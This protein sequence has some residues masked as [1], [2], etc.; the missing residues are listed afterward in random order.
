MKVL[1]RHLV[2]DKFIVE[3]CLSSLEGPFKEAM[4]KGRKLV[5]IPH[6]LGNVKRLKKHEIM[7]PSP[8]A[9]EYDWPGLLH[10]TPQQVDTVEMMTLNDR[11]FVN[12]SMGTGKTISSLWAADYLMKK[13]VIKRCL[14]V[15]PLSTLRFT[16][17]KA[18]FDNFLNRSA[19]V[20]DGPRA[21]RIKKLRE[22]HDFYIINPEGL[23]I[24][25]DELSLRHDINHVIVD[26]LAMF[27]EAKERKLNLN[28]IL[29]RKIIR[30]AWGMTGEPTPNAPT[31]A[32]W[33][34]RL[35]RPDLYGAIGG[36]RRF[37]DDTM[38]QVPNSIWKWVPRDNASNHVF[39][40]MQPS[41]RYSLED[42]ATLPPILYQ[43]RS[44]DMSTEQA[45]HYAQLIEHSKTVVTGDLVTAVNA[46]VLLSKLVQVSCGAVYSTEGKATFIPAT[47]RLAV[48]KEIIDGAQKKVIVFAPYRA[49]LR[50]IEGFLIKTYGSDRVAY[51][52][53]SIS[54]GDRFEIMKKFQ[55]QKTLKVLVAH[56]KPI[57]HG[58]TLTAADTNV[59]YAP[60][61]S[62]DIYSQ[63]NGRIYRI[64]QDSKTNV[65]NLFASKAEEKIYKG[66]I[67]KKENQ[68][69]LLE[70]IREYTHD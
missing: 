32:Y 22:E 66:L 57:S 68:D 54:K 55:E 5:A 43:Y 59:W 23:H 13:G 39:R 64:S 65:I 62:N 21:R 28:A 45:D 9:T 40:F 2:V 42:C 52:D 11:M 7:A 26:E 50:M 12:N 47:K 46:G 17:D 20:L 30:T 29:N 67:S 70:L 60:I 33:Q 1:K 8:V 34:I 56:P 14:I 10:P 44:V 27:R 49:V 61:T 41:V 38:V 51:I 35:I 16:W 69:I 18:I 58:V 24:L 63:A 25:V 53:G 3:D 48:L 6:T 4:H 31:D 15:A 36:W 37:R 19:A